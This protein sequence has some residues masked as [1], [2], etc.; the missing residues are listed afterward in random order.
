MEKLTG[1]G[2]HKVKVGNHLHKYKIS[3]QAIVRR[4][5]YK[6]RILEMNLK[7]K[8]QQLKTIL[9]IYRLLN[10]ILMVTTN[11]KSTIEAHT[12]KKS[13]SKYNTKVSYQITREENQR[14]REEKRHT[15]KNPKQ[16]RKWQQ[17]H[18]F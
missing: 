1:K 5:E 18:T 9:F 4:G 16:L 6:C 15:Q 2:K 13:E 12:K 10:Q 3:K 7:L 14:R 8:G 11:K 17:E